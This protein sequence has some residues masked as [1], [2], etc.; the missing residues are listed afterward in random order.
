MLEELLNQIQAFHGHLCPGLVMGIR[1]AEIALQEIGAHSAD[2]EVVAVVETDMCA[3]DAIQF[4]TGCTFGKGNLIH[5]DYGKN[6]YTFMRRSDAKAIR[7]LTKSAAWGDPN[8]EHRQL[9]AKVRNGT[10]LTEEKSRF[11]ELRVAK[12]RRILDTPTDELFSVSEIE[13]NPPKKPAFILQLSAL[14]AARRQWKHA[15][16]N[17]A[18]V[19]YVF[20][21][22]KKSKCAKFPIF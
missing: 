1:A 11:Q 6:A 7:V 3:I 12:A 18:G 15:S 4:L 13:T 19:I 16:A 5:R 9:S 21:V 2:E 10:A 22:L 14:I 8:D 20:R 17:L